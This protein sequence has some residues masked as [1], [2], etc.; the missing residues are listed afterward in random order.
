MKTH[1]LKNIKTFTCQSLFLPLVF[2]GIP[3]SS[4]FAE[5][6]SFLPSE[7]IAGPG[8]SKNNSIT[9]G[10]RASL[11]LGTASSFGSNAN[12]SSTDAYKVDSVSAFVPTQG[13]WKSSFGNTPDDIGVIKANV[14]NI[15][16]SGPGSLWKNSSFENSINNNDQTINESLDDASTNSSSTNET[17]SIEPNTESG[18]GYLI[19]ATESSTAEGIATLE[20]ATTDISIEINPDQTF[21]STTITYLEN[22]TDEN[23]MA[24]A[25][26][27]ASQSLNNSLNVDLSNTSFTN[28]FS[29][30]F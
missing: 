8:E 9:K 20:G 12:V 7:M 21:T 23:P 10:T 15:R 27:G 22:N 17:A 26:G 25:N 16:S 6:P 1:L 11:S 4:V 14:G 2:F 24:T 29:Q 28:S 3:Y 19:D 5:E 13:T 30:S 18:T